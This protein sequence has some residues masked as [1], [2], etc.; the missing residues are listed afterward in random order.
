MS[1]RYCIIGAGASGLAVAKTFVQRGIPFDLLEREA[2]IGGLWNINTPSGIVYDSTHLVSAITTTSFDDF[3]V[4]TDG[5][6]AG[7]DYPNHAWVLEYF[8][9]YARAFGVQPQLEFNTKVERVAPVGDGSWWVKIADET[10][11]R[12]YAGVVVANGHHDKPRRP[13]YPGTFSGEILHSRDYKSQRQLRDKRV[14]V[15]GAGNSG[16]D[17]VKDAAHVSGG[18]V[19]LSMR[20]GTWFVPKF[21]LGFPTGDVLANVEWLL[22]PLPRAVKAW[23]FQA[24]L[25]VLQGP[26]SR[27]KLPDPDYRIDHAHPTM[28]DDIP[29][30]SAH[31]RVLVRP[32]IARFEGDEVVFADGQRDRVDIVVLA[33]GYELS[34][35]F[36]DRTLYS[37]ANGKPAL[38]LNTVSPTQRGLFFAGLIQANG[39]IWRL[40]A[41]QGQLIA[42]AI[43][44][45]QSAPDEAR[46]FREHALR[47]FGAVSREPF[48]ASDRHLL[49]ANYF[50][51]ARALKKAARIF[52]R[53]AQ[54]QFKRTEAPAER[55]AELREAAE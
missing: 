45:E 37:D 27:Y 23:L 7:P 42:N 55:V 40:A 30:L 18:P 51:Y 44:A 15:V 39:S 47:N 19:L 41:L 12:H 36:L 26:P 34:I 2:D 49:E 43:A 9:R 14:L 20:R 16:C 53:A 8:R 17:I 10:D 28:S 50:D 25:W 4:T 1:E 5:P 3:V 6:R 38:Y 46:A 22:T 31:G 33:T 21:M 52:K 13:E 29:R 24:T 48:V 11:A 32:A 35:P 54:L